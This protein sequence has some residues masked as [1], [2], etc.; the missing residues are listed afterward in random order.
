MVGCETYL[1]D[2]W[3]PYLKERENWWRKRSLGVARE[4]P[5]LSLKT[6]RLSTRHQRGYGDLRFGV[7]LIDSPIDI[8]AMSGTFSLREAE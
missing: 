6:W 7:K 5:L 2:E 3:K 4:T 1:T 8:M